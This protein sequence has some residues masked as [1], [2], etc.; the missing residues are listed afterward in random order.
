MDTKVSPQTRKEVLQ[1]LRVRYHQANKA[2]KSRILDDFVALAGCHRKHAIRCLTCDESVGSGSMNRGRRI[3]AEAVREALVILWEAADLICDKRLK[4]I[5]P[6]LISSMERHQHLSLDPAVRELVLAVSAATI[7]RLL[8][9]VRTATSHGKYRRRA[10][11]FGKQIPVRTF[12]VWTYA[13]N[14]VSISGH[15]NRGLSGRY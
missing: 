4:A 2:D 14:P 1:S 8:S 10:T 9:D 5:L 6:S 13:A 7:D 15:P 12:A 11:P 3:Y